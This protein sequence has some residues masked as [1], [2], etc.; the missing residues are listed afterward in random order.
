[1]R[2]SHSFQGKAKP[3]AELEKTTATQQKLLGD[4]QNLEAREEG[5]REAQ[6]KLN[7]DLD[8]IKNGRAKIIEEQA[9]IAQF[10]ARVIEDQAKVIKDRAEITSQQATLREKEK[11][12]LETQG[13]AKENHANFK[14]QVEQQA[15]EKCEK[16]LDEREKRM[17]EQNRQTI[18]DKKENVDA[19]YE[20]QF[21]NRITKKEA[22]LDTNEELNKEKQDTIATR[23]TLKKSIEAIKSLDDS[24]NTLSPQR[25]GQSEVVGTL[26]RRQ[27]QEDD[28]TR[29][30]HHT[31]DT[32][33]DNYSQLDSVTKSLEEERGRH[34]ET[35]AALT[36]A[37][38]TLTELRGRIAG[39][40]G[41]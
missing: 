39:L 1:M 11:K 36:S 30:L 32:A 34:E 5:L 12:F 33:A 8:Q 16:L 35:C 23:D 13:K 21:I 24:L 20:K 26:L 31:H 19:Q 2:R 22:G 10:R 40:K 27:S 14:L 4:Q 41:E 25:L 38:N 17:K 7:Q 6:A 29:A 15:N 37:D 9:K 3:N 18:Q 28:L